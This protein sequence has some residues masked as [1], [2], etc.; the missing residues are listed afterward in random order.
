MVK[1]A[2]P[3]FVALP[4]VHARGQKRFQQLLGFGVGRQGKEHRLTFPIERLGLAGV[5]S[6]GRQHAWH[7]RLVQQGLFQG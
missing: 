1:K 3:L 4:E 5:V 7:A 2:A 6:K